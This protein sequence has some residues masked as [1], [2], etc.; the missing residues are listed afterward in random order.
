V[1]SKVVLATLIVLLSSSL[2]FAAPVLNNSTINYGLNQITISGLKPSS[3][4]Y[5]AD[6]AIQWRCVDAGFF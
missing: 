3:P 5:F 2:L 1:K 4:I 6:S